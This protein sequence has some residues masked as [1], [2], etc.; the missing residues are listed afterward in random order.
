MKKFEDDVFYD[1]NKL[2]QSKIV[3]LLNEA[4]ELS[5]NW[6]ID[7]LDAA[8]S[9]S[10]QNIDM[11]FEDALKRIDKSTHFV[12]INRKGHPDR[13]HRLEIGFRTMKVKDHFL[14]IYIDE[15]KLE[16]FLDKYGLEKL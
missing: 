5:Y 16:F 11:S 8:V 3:E 9:F 14:F 7:I 10:R 15:D 13:E 4:K 1:I 12:F 2:P 6:W